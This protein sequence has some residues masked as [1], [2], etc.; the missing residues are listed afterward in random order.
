M[1]A[2]DEIATLAIAAFWVFAL[3][4]VAGFVLIGAAI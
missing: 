3:L 4:V 2:R 1:I